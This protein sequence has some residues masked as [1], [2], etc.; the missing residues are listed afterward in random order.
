[1][2]KRFAT[3]YFACSYDAGKWLF[4]RNIDKN[5]HFK[6][7]YNAIDT[8]KFHFDAKSRIEIRKKLN[9]S[10]ETIIIGNI[11]R[12]DHQKNQKFL[13]KILSEIKK[14]THGQR[15]EIVIVGNG[16]LKNKLEKYTFNNKLDDYVNFVGVQQEPEKYYSAFDLF[17]FPS[18]FEGLG[19][20]LIESQVAGLRTLASTN[21]PYETNISE[22][23]EY[24]DG[25]KTRDWVKKILESIPE[26]NRVDFKINTPK[27]DIND[28][29]EFLENIYKGLFDE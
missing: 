17:V 7:I 29:S 28:S 6:I 15:Y 12:L 5:Q 16:Q 18:K 23:I 13:L 27:Y 25:F 10:D 24:I 9:I 2:S 11:G 4:G 14:M 26:K 21:V 22:I 3:H 20:A 1:M 8:K 19:I